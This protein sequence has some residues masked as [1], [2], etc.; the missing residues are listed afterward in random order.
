MKSRI[1]K[2]YNKN[3]RK[4]RKNRK[5]NINNKKYSRKYRKTMKNVARGRSYNCCMCN[6]DFESELP[7]SPSACFRKLGEKSH[8]ICP[9]CWWEKFAIE[10][11]NH[12]CPACPPETKQPIVNEEVIDLVYSSD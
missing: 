4:T 8:K 5:T 9:D 7:F 2:K 11:A 6:K 10:G 12:K 3:S 1:H